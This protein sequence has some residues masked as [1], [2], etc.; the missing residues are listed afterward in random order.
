MHPHKSRDEQSNRTPTSKEF[1]I[2]KLALQLFVREF[3][4]AK[5]VAVGKKAE[6]SLNSMGIPAAHVRHPAYGARPDLHNG[7]NCSLMASPRELRLSVSVSHR[8]EAES[9]SQTCKG[10][11]YT[12][13][14]CQRWVS[15][16]ESVLWLLKRK[17]TRKCL[18]AIPAGVD[19]VLDC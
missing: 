18:P 14:S 11:M 13:P 8:P 6:R 3:P 12:V 4:S 19:F 16:T 10:V 7:W 5:V 1:E 9:L 15:A 2:G 17:N